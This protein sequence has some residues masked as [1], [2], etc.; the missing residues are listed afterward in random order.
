MEANVYDKIKDVDLKNTMESSYIDY[1]MSVIV[2]RALPDVKDGLKPVQRRILYAALKMGATSDKKTKKCATIVGETMGHYHPHGD[3]SIYGALVNLG[4]PWSTKYPLIEKQGN[5]GSEDGDPPAAARYTEGKLSKISM[6]ML[7]AINKDTVDFVPNFSNEPGYDEP[8]VL[9]A[10]I[11][12]ILVN[13]TTGIAVGMATNMPPHNLRETITAAVRMIDNK[14]NENRETDIDELMDIVKGPDFP[15]G[16][17]IIGRQGIEEA[18]RTGRGKIRMRAVCEIETLPNGKGVI[19]VKELPYMVFRSRV[20]ETIAD[21]HKEKKID[22]ITAIN[23]TMGKNSDSKIRIELR[24]DVNPQVVLNQLYKH[25]QLQETFGVINLVIVNGEPKIL[26]LKEILVEY[27]KHQEDIVTRRTKFDLKKAQDRAH[28]L[29]G[30]LKAIDNIDEVINIIRNADDTDDAKAKL[31]ARFAFTEVQAQSIVDMRLKALTGLERKKVEDEYAELQKKISYFLEILGDK[32]KLLTVIR[33]EIQQIADKYGDERKT[34]IIPDANEIN[35]EDMISDDRM[36][37]TM[38]HLG[39]IKRMN[40]DNFRTQNRGGKGIKGTQNIENDY[41]EDMLVV[42][43]HQY[44]M[45][46]TNK[47]L[48]YRIKAYEIPEASRTSRGTNIANLL[49]LQPEEKITAAIA[50][51]EYREDAYIIMA[52][53][54]GM[55]KKTPLTDFANVRK[56]GLRAIVLR[57][58]D[59]LIEVKFTNGTEQVILVTKEGMSVRF[60]ENDIRVTGRAS[61]GVIGMRFKSETD[62]VIAMQILNQGSMLLVVS[63]YGMGKRTPIDEFRIQSRGGKGILCYRVNEK[64]GNLVAAKLVNDGTDIL[65]ITDHGQMM[66]TGIEGISVIGRNTSGVKLMNINKENGEHLVSIAKA[67]RLEEQET[68]DIGDTSEQ[69]TDAESETAS[70]YEETDPE[71]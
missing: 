40:E 46:F 35:I 55:I 44:I 16:A 56:N 21:L 30:L 51:K 67:R 22:G 41:V 12:N 64:T 63:E 26:N 7:D 19:T 25:T 4:Q 71:K 57:D 33:E 13:G 70:N 2:S 39:Y 36:I 42:T 18:Y 24:K 28:I 48:V 38:S 47:G 60:D 43:N 69:E 32:N 37:V 52:T 11:P 1:A 53:K 15:T 61:M 29:E 27:L 62:E 17:T 14:I 6:E 54:G 9:P 8:V 59:E 34:Q 49:M 68:E 58:N 31:I 3:S 66:R 23:D 50:I 10:R 20:I 5:F 65:L 45:F